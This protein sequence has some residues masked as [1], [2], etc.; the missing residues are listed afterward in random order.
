MTL[1]PTHETSTPIRWK[2]ALAERI[3]PQ[4]AEE[5]DDFEALRFALMDSW[6]RWRMTYG[7]D[8]VPFA[9]FA[10]FITAWRDDEDIGMSNYLEQTEEDNQLLW[11]G[12]VEGNIQVV[13]ISNILFTNELEI[14]E[15]KIQIKG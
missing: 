9:T 12:L 2:D 4:W 5:I 15:P 6:A 1:N 13:D 8:R 10:D 7:D 11:Q 3:D 14:F